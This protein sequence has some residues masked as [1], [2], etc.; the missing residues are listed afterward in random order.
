MFSTLLGFLF[1]WLEKIGLQWLMKR[2]AEQKAQDVANAPL[3]DKEEAEDLL[4]Q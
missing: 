1:S 4:K 2:R 3:T